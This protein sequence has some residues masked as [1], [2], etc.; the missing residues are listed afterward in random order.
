MR[1]LWVPPAVAGGIDDEFDSTTLNAA[2]LFR[3]LTTG[4]TNR[5]PN[6]ISPATPL[7]T[8]SGATTPPN[9]SVHTG[10]RRSHLLVQVTNTGPATYYIYK[11][12]TWAAGQVYYARL[13]YMQKI[14]GQTPGNIGLAMY[15]SNGGVPDVNNRITLSYN[16]G[17]N[18]LRSTSVAAGAST[19]TG[20][21]QTDGVGFP[22]YLAIWNKASSLG[23]SA[24]WWME[25]FDD[26]GD[27]IIASTAGGWANTFTP[28]FIGLIVTPGGPPD[29]ASFDF[30]RENVGH[31]LFAQ[32]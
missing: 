32:A 4:P 8:L 31:P 11:P 22:D 13:G 1:P 27:R 23:A 30:I 19:T 21:I 18:G 9:V 17:S 6:V 16:G 12:F 24:L 2:W 28:A 5:T 26:S 29:L 25:S 7:I 20:F 10:G 3:D 14:V 15:A